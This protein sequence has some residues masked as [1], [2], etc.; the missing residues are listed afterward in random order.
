LR[1]FL[2]TEREIILKYSYYL[3]LGQK[4]NVWVPLEHLLLQEYDRSLLPP[5]STVKKEII[6]LLIDNNYSAHCI[7][8]MLSEDPKIASLC[9][10]RR[11]QDSKGSIFIL[12]QCSW[13]Q[14]STFLDFL[15]GVIH[16][17]ISYY[18]QF[19][20]LIADTSKPEAQSSILKFS[21]L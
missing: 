18:Q 8:K 1:E 7:D 9:Q 2:D 6:L 13:E 16:L 21:K 15:A 14:L 19:L 3:K 10:N 11:V 12:P 4:K 5:F 20:P 17:H